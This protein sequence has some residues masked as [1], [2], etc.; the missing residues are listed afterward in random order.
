MHIKD[1]HLLFIVCHVFLILFLY[2]ILYKWPF[3]IATCI[4]CKSFIVWLNLNL[5]LLNIIKVNYD[6]CF[7]GDKLQNLVCVL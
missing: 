3:P 6:H 5:Q 2:I 1:W 7:S 4:I